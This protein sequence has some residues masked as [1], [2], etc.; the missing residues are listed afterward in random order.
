MS[1]KD[2]ILTKRFSNLINCKEMSD[3]KFIVGLNKTEIYGHQLILSMSSRRFKELFYKK[4]LQIEKE[5]KGREEEK[6][7]EKKHKKKKKKEI[8]KEIKKEKRKGTG[9][10]REKEKEIV[11]EKRKKKRNKKGKELGIEKKTISLPESNMIVITLPQVSSRAFKEILNYCY[12]RKLFLNESIAH[13]VYFLADYYQL[14]ELKNCCRKFLKNNLNSSNCLLL[15][16]KSIELGYTD[17]KDIILRTIILKSRELFSQKGSFQNVKPETIK[18]LLA[19]RLATQE[20]ELFRRI[21]ELNYNNS[22]KEE[23]ISMLK[24]NLL[25]TIGR[26][27]VQKSGYGIKHLNNFLKKEKKENN[28]N[29]NLMQNGELDF[30][31][32]TSNGSDNRSEKKDEKDE[33]KEKVKENL[34]LQTNINE[35]ENEK[36]KE[37]EKGIGFVVNAKLPE[38]SRIKKFQKKIKKIQLLILASTNNKNYIRNVCSSIISHGYLKKN[39]ICVKANSEIPSRSMLLKVDVIFIFSISPFKNAKILGDLL[40]DFVE[41]GRGIVICS[42]DCLRKDHER[43]LKGKIISKEFLPFLPSKLVHNKPST[44]GKINL[45]NHPILEGVSSFHGGKDS[46]H[47]QPKKYSMHSQRIAEWK[48]SQ[49]LISLKF[50]NNNCSQKH[51]CVIVLNFWPVSDDLKKNHSFWIPTTDGAKIIGNSIQFATNF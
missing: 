28:K 26:N 32:K 49:P 44:L 46:F 13:D 12:S 43:S 35:N 39:I 15:F 3:V 17:L 29:C 50:Y 21:L 42:P 45:P 4:R 5:I 20:I 1:K 11:H 23:L 16:Q 40:A 8:E 38:L 6:E 19:Q 37:K 33:E 48:N 22:V 31:K 47:L 7:K 27:E 25:G 9:A 18:L 30:V 36:E 14:A 2:S 41:S 24:F 10:G 34:N 51:G